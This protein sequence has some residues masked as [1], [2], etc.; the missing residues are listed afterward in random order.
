MLPRGPGKN[1]GFLT[2][3]PELVFAGMTITSL[4]ADAKMIIVIGLQFG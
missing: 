3:T 1:R 2:K 4:A